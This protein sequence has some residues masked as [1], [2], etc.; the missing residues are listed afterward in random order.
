MVTPVHST[1]R[2]FS[3]IESQH[4]TIPMP[5]TLIVFF[6]WHIRGNVSWL[7][8][9][10]CQHNSLVYQFEFVG[11]I[12]RIC[13]LLFYQ[14]SDKEKALQIIC[15]EIH[16]YDSKTAKRA[17]DLVCAFSVNN[18][19]SYCLRWLKSAFL[20]LQ[21]LLWLLLWIE[22]ICS[23]AVDRVCS[24][25]VWLSIAI[26]NRLA[27]AFVCCRFSRCL[28]V[29]HICGVW[30]TFVCGT[31]VIAIAFQSR[32]HNFCAHTAVVPTSSWIIVSC[33]LVIHVFD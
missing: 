4:W 25:S 9:H 17:H 15:N 24:H 21:L 3:L 23:T 27:G 28:F 8:K 19:R 33:S 1:I 13:T 6:I 18:A 29:F 26:Q 10:F 22:C 20:L 32:A 30:I 5:I 7:S 16:T 11:F 2:H 31:F 14:M 12:Q